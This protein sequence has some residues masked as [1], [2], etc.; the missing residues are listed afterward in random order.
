MQVAFDNSQLM[1]VISSRSRSNIKVT[2]LIKW[3]F[4]G[5]G[6]GI[7]VPQTHLVLMLVY[8]ISFPISREV[9]GALGY[10]D[11]RELKSYLEE[12]GI[13]CWMDVERVGKVGIGL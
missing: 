9:E 3:Q 5:W 7:S 1:R 6:G 4:W 10:G 13:H 12:H 2:F 11:P 8:E